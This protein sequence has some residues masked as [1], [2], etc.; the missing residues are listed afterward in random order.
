MAF[1]NL[2][3]LEPIYIDKVPASDRDV[4][5]ALSGVG[6]SVTAPGDGTGTFSMRLVGN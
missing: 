6:L 1:V 2:D 4:L 3:A 5:T